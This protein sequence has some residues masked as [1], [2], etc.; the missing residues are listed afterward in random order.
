VYLRSAPLLL[1]FGLAMACGRDPAPAAIPADT[2]VAV[3]VALRTIP[4]T[5]ADPDSARAAVL[6]AHGVEEGDLLA[7]LSAHE[8]DLELLATTWREITTKVD[9]IA[10][11]AEEILLDPE[12]GLVPY[13]EHP[14]AYEAPAPPNREPP[15]YRPPQVR[16]EERTERLPP[17]Q[18][19]TRPG[20]PPP[21]P[22]GGGDAPPPK[23]EPEPA[24]P[25]P[26]V[27]DTVGSGAG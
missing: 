26:I 16:I 11:P 9:S 12:S 23:P 7:F 20:P 22:P 27:P 19:V 14:E 25:N 10:T 17:P 2:F 18:P 4:D 5:V 13:D 6:E 8:R 1:A 21:P 24:A 3:N 15:A